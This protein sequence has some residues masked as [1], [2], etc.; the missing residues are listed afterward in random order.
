M[1]DDDDLSHISTTR[2]GCPFLS[3][4]KL[5]INVMRGCPPR[6][7]SSFNAPRA[8]PLAVSFQQRDEGPSPSLSLSFQCNVTRGCPPRRLSSSNATRRGAVPLAVSLLST[9]AR[10]C[11]LI[12]SPFNT[13]RPLRRYRGILVYYIYIYNVFN[14]FITSPY[15]LRTNKGTGSP[16]DTPGLPVPCPTYNNER[17]GWVKY[18]YS[19]IIQS[20]LVDS[21]ILCFRV[22][23]LKDSRLV[24][25]P[26]RVLMMIYNVAPCWASQ[27]EA[28]PGNIISKPII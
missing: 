17:C 25:L 3:H 27:V 9:Q 22:L 4:R 5:P 12:V 15:P 14:K 10:G 6:R 24:V 8:V 7:L 19:H 21:N 28:T 1:D 26:V 18:G 20:L 13:M 16:G 23:D 2:R 11:P